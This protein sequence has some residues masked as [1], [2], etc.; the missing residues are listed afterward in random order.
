MAPKL[1]DI[2]VHGA[3]EYETRDA[4]PAAILRLAEVLGGDGVAEC[5][6]S[7]YPAAQ[8]TMRQQMAA[9]RDAME[10][11]G[12]R[13]AGAAKILGVHL[14]GPFLN[15]RWA[16]ALNTRSFKRPTTTRLGRLLKGFEDTVR[17]ITIA[18]ELPGAQAV[19]AECAAMGIRVGMGH[20]DA[21]YSEALGGKRAG[22]TC[23][24][25]LFNAMRRMHHRE[26]GLAGLGLLD[27]DLYVEVVADGVHL[28]AEMLELVFRLKRKE[29]IIVVSDRV[30]GRMYRG[31]VLQGA[32]VSVSSAEAILAGMGISRRSVR[33]ATG[34]NPRRFLRGG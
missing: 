7:I 6:L 34:E 28:S 10:D 26:T 16:G 32:S 1:T 12:K 27:D 33:L 8:R 19:I 18:P 31:D 13:P 17:T 24:T 9:V 14:E 5:V 2:H 20:S 21:T 11:E 4:D 22:A 15:P 3:G 23:V 29:R 25:H 30:K